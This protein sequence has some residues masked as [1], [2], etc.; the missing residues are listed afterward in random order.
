MPVTV[1]KRIPPKRKRINSKSI[2]KT[3]KRIFK[4]FMKWKA[5][6]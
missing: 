2:P 4:I 1:P 3:K 6:S 5:N